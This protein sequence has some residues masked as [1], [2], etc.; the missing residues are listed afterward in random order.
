M[1]DDSVIRRCG[2]CGGW[3]YSDG[4]CLTCEMASKQPPIAEAKPPVKKSK[5]KGESK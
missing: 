2:N 4:S 3:L 5:P 1:I